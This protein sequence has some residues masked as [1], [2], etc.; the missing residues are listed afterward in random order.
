[1][2]TTSDPYKGVGQECPDIIGHNQSFSTHGTDNILEC[3]YYR[4]LQILTY[5]LN[6]V[7]TVFSFQRDEVVCLGV[8]LSMQAASYTSSALV[9]RRVSC[10]E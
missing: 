3:E 2:S 4:G 10:L 8:T 7:C 9:V 1:M 5:R 6:I